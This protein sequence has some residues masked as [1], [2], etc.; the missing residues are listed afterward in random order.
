[1]CVA[2]DGRGA[3]Q[4]MPFTTHQSRETVGSRG[5]PL[6]RVLPSGPLPPNPGEMAASPRFGET[7]SVLA[8]TAD[9]VLIDS[10]PNLEVGDAA[11]MAAKTDGVVFVVNMARAKWP[12]LE[13]SN[14]Q[15]EKFPC[16]KLGLVV[17][18]AKSAHK[19]VYG[20]KYRVGSSPG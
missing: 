12:M 6:L 9:L 16:R 3:D 11:A 5:E 10:P 7:I 8:D 17:F 18:A 13:R 14:A 2:T 19:P 15:L 1:M 4:V 20:Y